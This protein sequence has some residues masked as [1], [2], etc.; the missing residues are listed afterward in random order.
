MNS[1]PWI[2][3]PG[4]RAL[5]FDCDG[6]L[7]DTMPI[8][9]KA[10]TAMLG[11]HG[12]AFP[13]KRFYELGGVPTKQIIRILSE[14]QGVPIGDLDAM[15]REK[16]DLFLTMIDQ[17]QPVPAVYDIGRDH[18]H[19]FPMAVAS[20]GYRDVVERTLKFIGVNEWFQVVVCAEDTQRHKPEPDVFLEAARRMWVN[21]LAC[22]VFEDTD[23]GLEAA[24]RAGM[25]GVDVR[26][27]FG[28]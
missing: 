12:F 6:T 20:G 22:V 8:H 10:W 18:R 7:A 1:L 19:V 11:R 27:W 3:P 14:E 25:H 2:A 15:V 13:E 16:E 23:I 21:P 9:F 4:T 26:G 24:R 17:I 28:R 5:I